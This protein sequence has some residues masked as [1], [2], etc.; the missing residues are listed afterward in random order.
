MILEAEVLF[1]QSSEVE[2][3]K[4][5]VPASVVDFFK[6]HVF[7]GKD[8]ADSDPVGVPSDPAVMPDESELE[9]GRILERRQAGGKG[10]VGRCGGGP[11]VEWSGAIVLKPRE[12]SVICYLEYAGTNRLTSQAAL[13]RPKIV[14]R[15]PLRAPMLRVRGHQ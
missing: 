14:A 11:R 10:L 12:V 4:G 8:V 15:W 1:I 2:G 6:T 13:L 3:S 9:A 5:H 7:L